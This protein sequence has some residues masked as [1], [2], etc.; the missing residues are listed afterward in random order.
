MVVVSLVGR[1]EQ[2]LS[3]DDKTL[4]LESAT[5]LR[6]TSRSVLLSAH[7]RRGRAG[8]KS[9]PFSVQLLR[10]ADKKTRVF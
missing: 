8:A 10:L 4:L 1:T 5:L 3:T 6:L 9:E 2:D 7:L